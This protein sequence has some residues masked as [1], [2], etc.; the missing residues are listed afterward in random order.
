MVGVPPVFRV[1]IGTCAR[2]LEAEVE[3]LRVIEGKECLKTRAA[4][5]K[6]WLR[7]CSG[8]SKVTL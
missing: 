8:V 4:T 2:H 3:K 7:E 5:L 6:E 1:R